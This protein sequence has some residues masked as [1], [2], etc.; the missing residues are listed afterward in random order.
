[1]VEYLGEEEPSLVD[2]IVAK[3]HARTAAAAVEE[4]LAPILDDDAPT[5]VVKLW[6]MLCYEMKAAK[7]LAA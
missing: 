3:L 2:H 6:R 1:M 4:G 7:A 5:F